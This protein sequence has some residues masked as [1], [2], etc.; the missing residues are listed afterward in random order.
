MVLSIILFISH[1]AGEDYSPKTDQVILS[2]SMTSAEIVL[3]VTDDMVYEGEF[4]ESFGV[5]LSLL[6]GDNAQGVAIQ[7]SVVEILIEDND[8]RPGVYNGIIE[9]NL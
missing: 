9:T 8:P 7:Q 3:E 6:S 2:S 4:P 1:S 5:Q